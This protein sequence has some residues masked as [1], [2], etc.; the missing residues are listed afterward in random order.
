VPVLT[1]KLDPLEH[2]GK[3]VVILDHD[4]VELVIVTTRTADGHAQHRRANGLHDL[5]HAVGPGLANGGTHSIPTND[6]SRT[7]WHLYKIPAGAG[8]TESDKDVGRPKKNARAGL[9]YCYGETQISPSHV[10]ASALRARSI[11][12]SV[13]ALGAQHLETL[14]YLDF[15]YNFA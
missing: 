1:A 12:T 13:H 7:T 6:T 11:A 4:R 2:R 15:V 5:I 8:M 10:T 3:R 9:S 14:Q